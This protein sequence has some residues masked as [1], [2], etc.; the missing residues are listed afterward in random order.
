MHIVKW[1]ELTELLASF[2]GEPIA[3]LLRGDA[4]IPPGQDASLSRGDIQGMIGM[5]SRK[6]DAKT[7]TKIMQIMGNALH[8]NGDR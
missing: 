1:S 7:I 8:E 3:A 5:L 2:L 6:I 4:V